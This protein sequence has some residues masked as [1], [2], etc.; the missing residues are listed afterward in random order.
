[1]T[2]LQ[3]YYVYFEDRRLVSHLGLYLH[4]NGDGRT[5]R[6]TAPC[7]GSEKRNFLS[8]DNE[9][10]SPKFPTGCKSKTSNI[11][12]ESKEAEGFKSVKHEEEEEEDRSL[13][14]QSHKL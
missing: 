10:A 14:L 4:K 13:L 6:Y 2:G 5:N 1:M 11:Y 12:N 7:Y 3:R 8:Y 9:I